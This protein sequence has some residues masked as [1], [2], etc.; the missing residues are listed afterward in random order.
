MALKESKECILCVFFNVVVLI[1]KYKFDCKT[2]SGVFI[3]KKYKND[4]IVL[5]AKYTLKMGRIGYL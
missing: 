5:C 3:L 1:L 4:I 2:I